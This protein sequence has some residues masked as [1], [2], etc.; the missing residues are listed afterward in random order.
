MKIRSTI[1]MI[2]FFLLAGVLFASPELVKEES[3]ADNRD[4][5]FT[6]SRITISEGRYNFYSATGDAFAWRTQEIADGTVQA[7]AMWTGGLETHGY[8]VIFRLVNEYN[9]YFVLLAGQGY[10]LVGKT[11]EGNASVLHPWSYEPKLQEHGTNLMRVEMLNDTF[12][13]FLN[14]TQVYSFKDT[15]FASGGYG[16]FTQKGVRASFDDL[17]VWKTVPEFA[18]EVEPSAIPADGQTSALQWRGEVGKHIRLSFPEG[19][20]PGQVWGSDEY[21][22]DSSIYSAAVHSGLL[23]MGA[24]GVVTIEIMEGR[25][26]FEGTTRNGISSS[27][28]G[29]W[30]GSFRLIQEQPMTN[31]VPSYRLPKG[32][33]GFWEGARDVLGENHLQLQ[34]APSLTAQGVRFDAKRNQFALIAN[35]DALDLSKGYTVSMRVLFNSWSN[36]GSLADNQY[37][38]E[39]STDEPYSSRD[40]LMRLQVVGSYDYANSKHKLAMGLGPIQNLKVASASPRLNT[41][42]TITASFDGLYMRMYLD[43]EPI[44]IE[45]YQYHLPPTNKAIFIAAHEHNQSPAYFADILLDGLF[46]FNRALNEEE[47]DILATNPNFH[48]ARPVAQQQEQTATPQQ[49]PQA[50]SSAAELFRLNHTTFAPYDARGTFGGSVYLKDIFNKEAY[51]AYIAF[52][53]VKQVLGVQ[54]SKDIADFAVDGMPIYTATDGNGFYHVNLANGLYVGVVYDKQGTAWD[55]VTGNTVIKVTATMKVHHYKIDNS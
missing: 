51:P 36:N 16:F 1:L 12:T 39:L 37:L 43:G 6:D 3:F 54:G 20:V 2:I 24:A 17:K 35:T 19:L 23:R 21:T 48:T 7:Q 46:I 30:P 13:L 25:A 55:L 47:I 42:H 22:D 27:P 44:L 49:P 45:E 28:F 11:V 29:P 8:G 10:Y 34:N 31:T 18:A 41:W 9:Y 38:V 5:W 4:L 40:F 15:S 32:S 14:D 52:Y 50:P 53:P 33:I 26:S